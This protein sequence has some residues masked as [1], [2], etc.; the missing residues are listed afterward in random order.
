MQAK[1]GDY[2]KNFLRGLENPGNKRYFVKTFF[3]KN[4]KS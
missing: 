3:G 1:K 2:G 4:R